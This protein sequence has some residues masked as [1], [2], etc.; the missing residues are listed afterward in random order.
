MAENY[1]TLGAVD[2][3]AEVTPQDKTM[4]QKSVDYSM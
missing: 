3:Q 1:G 4:R 2:K